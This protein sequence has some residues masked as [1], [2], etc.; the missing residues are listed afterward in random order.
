MSY[1]IVGCS[2][3][4]TRSFG[5]LAIGGGGFV[6]AI[7][8]SSDGNTRLVRTDT[9]GA[10]RWDGTKWINTNTPA[11]LGGNAGTDLS[12]AGC[13]EIVI[14]PGNSS[15][16]Y[17]VMATNIFR[18]P[19]GG[20][21]WAMG[22]AS[23]SSNDAN[24]QQNRR[25]KG[26]K[27]AVCP[28]DINK[29]YTFTQNDGLYYSSNG[30]TSWAAVA[31]VPNPQTVNGQPG[32]GIVAF[33]NDGV[34][35][36]AASS[37]HGVYKA[38]TGGAF[39][40]V[41]GGPGATAG[42]YQVAVSTTGRFFFSGD[43]TLG[44]N[45]LWRYTDGSPGTWV[46]ITPASDGN[47]N[48][49]A[50]VVC[51]PNNAN[52]VLLGEN[53][54]GAFRVCTD[55]DATTPSTWSAAYVPFS[56]SVG[57]GEPPWLTDTNELYMSEGSLQFDPVTA[58]RLWFAEGIGVWYADI[59]TGVPSSI[60]WN[61]QTRGIE[62]MVATKIA[63]TPNGVL[64]AAMWDRGIFKFNSSNPTAFPTRQQ[65]DR[66]DSLNHCWHVD[67]SSS[68]PT[69][70]V[71]YMDNTHVSAAD[72]GPCYSTDN[73]TTWTNFMN[74]SNT[75]PGINQ[76]GGF[77]GTI[78][79]A[80]PQKLLWQTQWDNDLYYSGNGGATWTKQDL[81]SFG[82][83]LN[84]GTP[85]NKGTNETGWGQN[86]QNGSVRHHVVCA[87]R[88]TPGI[89]YAFNCGSG[90][91]T[92]FAGIYKLDATG[93][94]TWS[95]SFNGVLNGYVYD[96]WSPWL[97]SVPKL[98]AVDTTGHLFY[99]SGQ[100]G[101]SN[102]AVAALFRFSL[103]GGATW[104]SIANMYEVYAFGFGA[105]AP[106]KDYPTVYFNGWFYN[107]ATYVYGIYKIEANFTAWQANTV[108]PVFLTDYPN[109]W[110]DEIRTIDGDKV[111]RGRF[112]MGFAGSG[113]MY[114]NS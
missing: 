22:A 86:S 64:V 53:G 108:V 13:F 83:P 89:F 109:G 34:S 87:D 55:A 75:S 23:P 62:Q 51:D 69:Y 70:L 93:T 73:G 3:N 11:G 2:G 30:G 49:T 61:S 52:R 107:G 48:F 35:I 32:Q 40:A 19:D 37:G 66:A 54:G 91:S 79:A 15:I 10:Y 8:L 42:L 36:L 99:T 31:S 27:I 57:A 110:T 7:R 46:D 97:A 98:T 5:P 18:S 74:P 24:S 47:L 58:N 84:N 112:Y 71:S 88:G 1:G 33:T 25:F 60:A 45:K 80:T 16:C 85:G 65:I 59:G 63:A 67:W 28:T 72:Y 43:G 78:V 102:P 82:V 76:L 77:G 100:S 114:G 81:S 50:S 113:F 26:P 4:A 12:N 105:A 106:G 96:F 95:R 92:A 6:T 103:N 94:P 90:A 44:E 21:T 101:G 104:T 111:M 68:D 20:K 9:F 29:V 14:A 39:T 41:T 56:R 38:A 17:M